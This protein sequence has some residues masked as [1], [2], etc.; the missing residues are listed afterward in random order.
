M[1]K[2]KFDYFGAFGKMAE[3]SCMASEML[4]KI[5]ADYDLGSLPDYIPKM[6]KFEH[7]ADIVL[8]DIHEHLA[9]E[10]ITPIERVD[11]I[12]M[13]KDLDDVNDHIEDVLLHLYMYNLQDIPK[14]ADAMAAI[15]NKSCLSLHSA[16]KEFS[17][18]KKSRSIGSLIIEINRLEEDADKIY[19]EANHR[20]FSDEV[21]GPA[22]FGSS[23]VLTCLEKCCDACEHAADTIE[24]IIMKNF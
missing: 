20:L 15:I 1:K 11:I 9:N 24:R 6:H 12:H 13:A 5:L 17:N 3:Y 16:L 19:I 10:F 7:D 14:E 4:G 18:F 8:H 21:V 2:N 22:V 23:A